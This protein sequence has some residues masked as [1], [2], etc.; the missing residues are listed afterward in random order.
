MCF[1][2][3]HSLQKC[4]HQQ[5]WMAYR[6]ANFLQIKQQIEIAI[7][8]KHFKKHWWCI[9]YLL[10]SLSIVTEGRPS[11]QWL[12]ALRNSDIFLDNQALP[13]TILLMWWNVHVSYF[14]PPQGILVKCHMHFSHM[15][16]KKTTLHINY[17]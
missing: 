2:K 6:A 12:L 9:S 15:L 13:I 16:R 7:M 5:F 14:L 1:Q 3:Y 11:D 8:L 10:L 4:V 17:F